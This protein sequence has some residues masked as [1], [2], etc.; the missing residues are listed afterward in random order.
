M[1]LQTITLEEYST[2]SNNGIQLDCLDSNGWNAY[3]YQE[4]L[5]FCHERWGYVEAYTMRIFEFLSKKNSEKNE[6]I[7]MIIESY[8]LKP[9]KY[10]VSYLMDAI[11]HASVFI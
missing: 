8:G 9:E 6:L 4:N 11:S 10:I 3:I 5:Y 2:I 1:E 7:K